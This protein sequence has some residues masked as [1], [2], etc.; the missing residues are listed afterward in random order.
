MLNKEQKIGD[1]ENSNLNQAGRDITINNNGVSAADVLAIVDRVVN[2]KMMLYQQQAENTA[3]QR[4]VDFKNSL[5]SEL[6]AKTD[7][8]L[9]R[10]ELPSV[11]MSTR[12]AA[13][14]YIQSGRAED[15]ENLI[16]LLI[17]RINVEEYTTKQHLIDKAIQVLPML[18]TESLHLL[19]FV[20]F[21]S[22]SRFCNNNEY[23]KWVCSI[24]PIIDTLDRVGSLDIDFLN[25]A[26]CSFNGL[27]FQRN[28]FIDNEIKN[29][30]LLFRHEPSQEI[31]Q[32][33]L[34]KHGIILMDNG[35][36]FV[37]SKPQNWMIAFIEVF[38]S[39][40]RTRPMRAQL[41]NLSKTKELLHD[42][43]FEDISDDLQLYYDSTTPFSREEVVKYYTDINQNW[44][45]AFDL[46]N[47]R[48]IKS[49]QLKPVGI[50]IACRILSRLSKSDVSLGIFYG[51]NS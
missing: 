27:G 42:K 49:L 12:D 10:F 7:E 11:Q 45:V 51:E 39:F 19:S 26:D 44:S 31:V 36:Q 17:E 28:D 33:I 37:N 35:Y 41:S 3:K 18:S 47:R 46:L 5:I 21:T 9:D 14:G 1:V 6:Q 32:Q 15:K 8:R 34:D 2:D 48:D 20:V 4:L 24:N 29:C 13:L 16:D 23:K 22:L 50:Y 43:G 38:G 30:D 25:Q 40:S